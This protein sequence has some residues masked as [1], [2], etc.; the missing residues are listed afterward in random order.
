MASHRAEWFTAGRLEDGDRVWIRV[1]HYA[2]TLPCRWQVTAYRARSVYL[3][4]LVGERD[5]EQHRVLLHDPTPLEAFAAAAVL[6]IT[7]SLPIATASTRES[8]VRR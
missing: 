6:G 7:P 4:P 8:A 1:L 5:L 3:G 2:D